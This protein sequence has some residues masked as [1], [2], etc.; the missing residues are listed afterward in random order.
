MNLE[1]NVFFSHLW[2]RPILFGGCGFFLV[3][4]VKSNSS[5]IMSS[6][7]KSINVLEPEPGSVNQLLKRHFMPFELH[8]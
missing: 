5:M 4:V 6:Q 2:Y 3:V 8:I 7:I 1:E